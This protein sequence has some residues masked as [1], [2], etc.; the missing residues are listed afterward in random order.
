MTI[1]FRTAPRVALATFVVGLGLLASRTT[2]AEDAACRST[3]PVDWPAASKPYFMIIVDTSGSMLSC[4]SDASNY[5][6]TGSNGS[7]SCPSTAP[8]N[9]CGLEPTRLNDAKCAL[10][11]TINAFGGQVNFGLA[12]FANRLSGCNAGA[13]CGDSC[14]TSNGN[15]LPNFDAGVNAYGE[16]Y[17]GAG[18]EINPAPGADDSC[19]NTPSCAGAGP[20]APNFAKGTWDNGGNILVP[21][22]QDPTWGATKPASNVPEILKYF[23]GQCG[24]SKEIFAIG[25][26]PIAGALKSVQQYLKG[27]WNAAW[28]GSNYC[29]SGFAYGAG[30]A[31]P[32][33]VQDRPCRSV[34]VLLVTDGDQ[35][36]CPGT[37]KDVA[38]E[39]L[40]G[41]KVGSNTFPVR[42]SVIGFAGASTSKIQEIATAGGGKALT[43]NNETELAVALSDIIAGA[44]PAEVCDNQ[45]NNCNGCTDE[46][47]KVYC[48]RGRTATATPTQASQ[49][50]SWTTAA[51]R[52][53]CLTAHAATVT[54]A[55]PKG[56]TFKLPCFN[57]AAP[58]AGFSVEK[59]WLCA[60]PG[61]LCD[62]LDNNCDATPVTTEA[63]FG[64]NQV[65]E[66][67]NKCANKKG[68]TKLYCPATEVCDGIDQ[69]CDSIPDNQPNGSTPYGI[70]PNQCASQPETCNG[71]DEDCDGI[72]D[73]GITA[74]TCGPPVDPAINPNCGGVLACAPPS[75]V[76]V[77]GCKA[78][79]PGN[80]FSCTFPNKK[81]ETCNGQDD[82]C[83]GIIDNL[84]SA[85]EDCTPPGLENLNYGPSSRCK[86]G[87]KSGCNG[88][89]IGFVGPGTEVCNGLDDDCD[90]SV[91]EAVPGLGLT[92][93]IA[94]P[95]CKQGVTA[96]VNGAILCTGSTPPSP[97]IC[98]GI[99]NNC[100]GSV[101]EPAALIDAP[102]AGD[103]GCWTE[104]TSSCPT[105]CTY[106][107][108]DPTKG[109]SWC[110]PAGA[111]CKDNG[112]LT[113]P[114]FAG[115]L[116]CKEG[117]WKCGG[118][119]KPAPEVCD[120]VDN[121]CN[122]T[123]DTDAAGVGISCGLST[124]N[125]KPWF[126]GWPAGSTCTSGIVV[127][128]DGVNACVG[129]NGQPTVGPAAEICDGLDNDCDG[130]TDEG[131]AASDTVCAALYDTAAYPG[132]RSLGAC[133]PG[134]QQCTPGANPGEAGFTCVDAVGPSPEVCDGIDNDCDGQVDEVGPAPDGITGTA[135]PNDSTQVIGASCGENQGVCAEGKY[136]CASGAFACPKGTGGKAVEVCDC[137]DNDCDGAV[138]EDGVDPASGAA[139]PICGVGKACA[140]VGGS[141]Q[142]VAKCAN[143]EFPC[144]V[145]TGLTCT[146]ITKSGT[147][148]T[149]TNYCVGSATSCGGKDCAAETVKDAKGVVECAPAAGTTAPV[150]VC[151][152]AD[153]QC[154]AP[155]FGV[156]ACP[157]GFACTNFGA[158]AGTCVKNDCTNVPCPEGLLCNQGG[159]VTDPCLTKGCAAN[160]V[161]RAVDSFKSAICVKSCADVVCDAGEAC[162][163]G[164]CAP[165]G[166][167][168]EGCK[169][170]EVCAGNQG[171]SG[172]A[173]A[174]ANANGCVPNKCGATTCGAFQ[175][176]DPLTGVCG[177]DP[178]EGVTCPSGQACVAGE[179]A[180][181][182]G[183]AGSSGKGGSGGTG[184][185]AGGNGAGGSSAGGSANVGGASAT[186]GA[187]TSNPDGGG[188][189]PG[190]RI[191]L[192][193][194]GGGCSTSGE[195]TANGGLVLAGFLA[196]LFGNRGRQRRPDE[197]KKSGNRAGAKGGVQ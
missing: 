108:A 66:G 140:K 133:R 175:V 19:G 111:S 31:T 191:G 59:S 73:N 97:E 148:E 46:G 119:K 163:D 105:A 162:R 134:K 8:K 106:V 195:G 12:V 161:C 130:E 36:G 55:N 9:S 114:C 149:L 22:P 94:T 79:G 122:G 173:G 146:S 21:L 167:P 164:I 90:G 196:A 171:S 190:A 193:S 10:Q 52:T 78:G 194:G 142:C 102:A 47:S 29:S 177:N 33:D 181:A 139:I 3:N 65:D 151:K 39:L 103:G 169:A 159:C 168:V 71:C 125:T 176:C 92:C 113:Q 13:A 116:A 91:D 95:P 100:N 11:N 160:E 89:C 138:D 158:S 51:Q 63:A 45:D 109:A 178:C 185:G 107:G 32:L 154:H 14:T 153:T 165:T 115:V 48:N 143:G 98:D 157:D 41:V 155:C 121:D 6:F 127:C 26:T 132:D 135:N 50:C 34:N 61:E 24:D 144:P 67:F 54:A 128:K 44:I 117:A 2:M 38:A 4:T 131:I 28:G 174:N 49:C 180:K 75:N 156:A 35:S 16:Y 20:G 101:D 64:T 84:A 170:G 123:T 17:K 87:K 69:D 136:E 76:G 112:G 15:C 124:D 56:D 18:C 150:C 172:A 43:A 120:G 147:D 30:L 53:A 197:R 99:D 152:G 192:A 7:K 60:D 25:G 81:A 23:D 141:C 184:A 118:G 186:G 126:P 37:P 96:C 70:C 77:N 86:K 80:F 82:D 110:P 166:C 40:A 58:V 27:G 189:A 129:A 62:E 68:D 74:G 104:P 145:G 88:S 57:P 85:V 42:T 187:G 93:G 179:C 83:D 137:L 188:L 183:G 5:V 1:R 182:T 72:A